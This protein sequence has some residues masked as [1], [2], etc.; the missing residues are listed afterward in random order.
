MRA[1]LKIQLISWRRQRARPVKV[2]FVAEYGYV[3]QEKRRL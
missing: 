3:L 1:E 2:Q